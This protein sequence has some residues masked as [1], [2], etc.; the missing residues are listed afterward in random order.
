M[1]Q[2]SLTLPRPCCLVLQYC[3]NCGASMFQSL[4]SSLVFSLLDSRTTVMPLWPAFHHI[5]YHGSRQWWTMQLGSSF[6]LQGSTTCHSAPPP[7]SLAEGFTA[8]SFQV[9]HL[10]GSAMSYLVDELCQVADIRAHRWVCSASSSSLI[11]GR[12]WLSTAEDRAVL[13][14]ASGTIYPSTLLLHLWCLSSGH[15]SRFSFTF[16]LFLIPCHM[17]HLS[18]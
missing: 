12:T 18:L 2:W 10:H 3:V 4:M 7:A 9:C 15:V 17:W 6:L 8:D 14:A 11:I 13:V 1:S 5:L 16:L